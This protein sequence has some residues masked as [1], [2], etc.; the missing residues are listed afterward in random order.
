MSN[1]KERVEVEAKELLDKA[2]KLYKFIESDL[3]DGL[4]DFEYSLLTTQYNVMLSYYNILQ[5][6][7]SIKEVEEEQVEY[8][9]GVS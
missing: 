6:R 5:L 9:K 1:W 4:S 3:S 7:L 2:N 8:D